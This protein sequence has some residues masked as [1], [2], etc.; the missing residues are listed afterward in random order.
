M[1]MAGA[2]LLFTYRNRL[3]LTDTE[4]E[5]TR[6]HGAWE[7]IQRLTLWQTQYRLSWQTAL[8]LKRHLLKVIQ[9]FSSGD[10]FAGPQG[11]LAKAEAEGET[12]W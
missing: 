11:D 10:K 6:Q 4:E 7:T 12:N 2:D 9:V 1:A 5:R 8:D 3:N